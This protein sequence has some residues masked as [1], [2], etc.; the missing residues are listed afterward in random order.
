[1]NELL[2]PLQGGNVIHYRVGGWASDIDECPFRLALPESIESQKEM[3]TA[4][5]VYTIYI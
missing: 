3:T 1:M 2:A 4:Y 5:I